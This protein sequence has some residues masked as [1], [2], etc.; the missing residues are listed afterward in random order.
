MHEIFSVDKY[1]EKIKFD[2]TWGLPKSGVHLKWGR[3]NFEVLTR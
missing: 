1:E 3:Q 2:K